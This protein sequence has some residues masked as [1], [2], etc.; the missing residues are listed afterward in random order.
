MDVDLPRDLTGQED[1]RARE[2][3]YSQELQRA[4][5]WIHI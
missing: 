4:G 2:K 1:L 5:K 3:A